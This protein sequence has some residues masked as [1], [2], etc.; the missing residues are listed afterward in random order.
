MGGIQK[1]KGFK[2][3]TVIFTVMVLVT[4]VPSGVYAGKQVGSTGVESGKLMGANTGVD[5]Q[6]TTGSDG[7]STLRQDRFGSFRNEGVRCTF[8]INP[9]TVYWKVR[10]NCIRGKKQ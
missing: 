2:I 6:F 4:S 7:L 8:M 5:T 9:V 10:V 1:T 3:A